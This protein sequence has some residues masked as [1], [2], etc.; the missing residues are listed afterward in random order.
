MTKAVV[1]RRVD[2]VYR[3]LLLG[4]ERSRIIE[5][6]AKKYPSWD[7][8][9]RTVDGYI[10][11]AGKLIIETGKAER[12]L[13]FGRS[14]ARKHMIFASCYSDGDHRGAL[15]A[16]DSIDA[17]FGFKQPQKLEV[18]GK[19]GGA[20]QHEH[21]FS[22]LSDEELEAAI[23]QEAEIITGRAATASEPVEPASAD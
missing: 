8:A 19:A 4:L 18:T 1:A 20:I 11:R 21:D 6:I 10:H 2:I 15:A 7:C 14:L 12:P 16:Q 17:M 3:L 22:H 5:H 23:V 13:E 9:D